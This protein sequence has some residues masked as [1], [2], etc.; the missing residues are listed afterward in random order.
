M[1]GLK[2]KSDALFLCISPESFVPTDHPLRPIRLMADKALASL[3]GEFEN[4]NP[5]MAG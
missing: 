5:G 4:S 2:N 1:R 3:S